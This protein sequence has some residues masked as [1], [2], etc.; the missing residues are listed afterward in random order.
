[1]AAEVLSIFIKN[2][3]NPSLIISGK[4]FIITQLADDTNIFMR[5]INET[6]KI[7]LFINCFWRASG[8]KWNKCELMSVHPTHLTEA[9][10]ITTKN[11]VKYFGVLVLVVFRF[12]WDRVVG[13]ADSAE[14]PRRP[15]PQTPPPAPPAFPGQPR[16]IVPPACPGPPPGGTYLEHLPRKASRRHL[17]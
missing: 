12:I 14:T 4:Q 17:V 7:N 11:S 8:L 15:S 10:K 6:P 13:A 5:D 3:Y 1:M 16:D 9:H 2:S